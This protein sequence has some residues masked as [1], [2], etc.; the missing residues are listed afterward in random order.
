MSFDGQGR[1]W[2]A[3]VGRGWFSKGGK[4]TAIQYVEWDGK[5]IPFAIHSASLTK[6]GFEVKFTQRIGRKSIP[7][8]TVGVILIQHLR[9][10]AR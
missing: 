5:T 1:L 6:T 9:L 10:P 2:S 3:Q 4:R 8:V 7:K